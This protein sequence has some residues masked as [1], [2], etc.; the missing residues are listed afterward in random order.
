V[1]IVRY[2]NNVSIVN[3]G[4]LTMSTSSYG[5]FKVTSITAGSGSFSFDPG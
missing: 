5:S 4:G 3:N 1:L 2:P